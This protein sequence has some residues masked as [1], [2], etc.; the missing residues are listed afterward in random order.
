M[1]SWKIVWAI[2]HS[3]N[4]RFAMQTRKQILYKLLFYIFG[5][6][7][8]EKGKINARSQTKNGD[9]ISQTPTQEGIYVESNVG[10]V[11][12]KGDKC[13]LKTAVR[14]YTIF[15]SVTT[16]TPTI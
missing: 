8:N 14:I 4:N 5:P 2:S 13:H 1:A 11:C 6:F 9:K 10:I 15:L 16:P 12:K 7:E 3:Q